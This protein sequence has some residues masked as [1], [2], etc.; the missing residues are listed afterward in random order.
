MGD[1]NPPLDG[2]S[3]ESQDHIRS[4]ANDQPGEHDVIAV[5]IEGILDHIGHVS[6]L[7]HFLD[8]DESG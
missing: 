2:D 1:H 6:I 8:V 3:T 7:K 5:G 4:H